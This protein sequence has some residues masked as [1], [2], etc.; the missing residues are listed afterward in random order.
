M[1]AGVQLLWWGQALQVVFRVSPGGRWE[2]LW[3][4][5]LQE[6]PAVKGFRGFSYLLQWNRSFWS[7][8]FS[9]SWGG[10]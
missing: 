4:A 5:Q 10:F 8:T 2:Q 6:V 1:Q 3:A 9:E 7:V